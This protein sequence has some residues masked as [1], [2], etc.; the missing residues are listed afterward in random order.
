MPPVSTSAKSICVWWMQ[1]RVRRSAISINCRRNPSSLITRLNMKDLLFLNRLTAPQNPRQR[2][3]SMHTSDLS[4][5]FRMSMKEA[6]NT[7]AG[8]CISFLNLETFAEKPS[9]R[10]E[11]PWMR[12]D[13]FG[14]ISV[15]GHS[16]FQE[17]NTPKSS[18]STAVIFYKGYHEPRHR[19][20]DSVALGWGLRVSN[21]SADE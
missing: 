5:A 20:S 17:E 11:V 4:T 10:K 19:F 8:C 14:K 13:N 3:P 1:P 6:E 9:L 16:L 12:T 21:E 15:L 18:D 7:R 2:T